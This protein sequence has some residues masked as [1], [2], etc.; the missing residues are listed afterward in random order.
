MHDK[1]MGPNCKMEEIPEEERETYEEFIMSKRL[2][3]LQ[4]LEE[5]SPLSSKRL[6]IETEVFST[7]MRLFL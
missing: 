2:E 7:N 4:Q 5:N 6:Y 1:G 3:K